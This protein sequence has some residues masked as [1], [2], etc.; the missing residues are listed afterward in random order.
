T[1]TRGLG[2]VAESLHSE[3]R[4]APRLDRALEKRPEC[5][6]DGGPGF[7]PER[8]PSVAGAALA[9]HAGH[10]YAGDAARDNE[11]EEREVGAHIEREAMHRDPLLH[12]NADARDLAPSPPGPDPGLA[13]ITLRGNAEY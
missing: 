12:V 9:C 13:G 6:H 7:R 10:A 3:R 4:H 1:S 11:V 5:R 2:T 8:V